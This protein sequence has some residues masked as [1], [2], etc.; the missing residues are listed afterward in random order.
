MH[1]VVLNFVQF[2][3]NCSTMPF[4]KLE[5]SDRYEVIIQHYEFPIEFDL[6]ET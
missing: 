4:A 2:A 3:K 1:I 5:V 6:N